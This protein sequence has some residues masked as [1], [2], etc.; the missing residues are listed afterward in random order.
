MKVPEVKTGAEF[1]DYAS[2][3]TIPEDIG[4]PQANTQ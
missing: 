1:P 3:K 4:G 2:N